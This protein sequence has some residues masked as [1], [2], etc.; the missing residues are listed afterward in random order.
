MAI[1]TSERYDEAIWLAGMADATPPHRPSD[2]IVSEMEAA[3]PGGRTARVSLFGRR[4]EP[5]APL[6]AISPPSAVEAAAHDALLREL[7]AS[8]PDSS[9]A[10]GRGASFRMHADASRDQCDGTSFSPAQLRQLGA[11]VR[12]RL[13]DVWRALTPELATLRG[14]FEL[15]TGL[16]V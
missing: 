8:L 11:L 4:G 3:L 14:S 12:S 7:W 9:V 10:G 2:L 16:L 6:L 15:F 1:V 5:S 13:F